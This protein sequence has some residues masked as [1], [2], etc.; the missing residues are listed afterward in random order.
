MYQS[1]T[2]F[3]HLANMRE[4]TGHQKG[5]YKD[6]MKFISMKARD[7]GVPVDGKFELTP[8]CNLDCKMCYVHLNA[9][10]LNDRSILTVDTWKNLMY[11]AWEAGMLSAIL[12]GGDC[13]T[14]PGFDDLFLYLHSLGCEVSV[15]T[16]GLLL[17]EKRIQF[18]KR[19]LPAVVQVTLYGSNDEI[20][21]KVTG[22]R[23]FSIVEKN[24]KRAIEADI[25][26]GIS[27]TPN[28][29]MGED[30]IETVRVA[31]GLC[32]SVSI[33]YC[34]NAPREETGRSKHKDEI[35]LELFIKALK[36]LNE[37]NGGECR[38]IDE[39]K[40]PPCGGPSHET[41]E[42]G[43]LCG[44]GRSS[45]AIDWEGTMMPCVDFTRIQAYPLKDG[46]LNAWH[47]V[48][49]KANNWPRVPECNGCAYYDVCNRCAANMYQFAEPGKMPIGMCERTKE[50]VRNGIAHIPDCE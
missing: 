49:R 25:P 43:L 46:F 5:S 21:E 30:I 14:Y 3:S 48:N 22:R 4:K 12:T 10:Q 13:L 34:L 35:E 16:N 39:L 40:L 6:A 26:V 7:K 37:L 44:G 19:H 27:I 33:N 17:D 42:C 28:K 24:I 8:L 36:Y 18:F 2:W 9:E 15:L 47:E 41:S 50:M 32:K 45:F 29:Y 38:E 23:V 20:Y 31:R 1:E 11:Q